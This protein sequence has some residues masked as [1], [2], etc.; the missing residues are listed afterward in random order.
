MVPAAAAA[1]SVTEELGRR[2][3]FASLFPLLTGF[4]SV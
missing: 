4:D 1:L 2:F 3:A